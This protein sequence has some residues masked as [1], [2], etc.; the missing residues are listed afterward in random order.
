[1]GRLAVDNN[2]AQLLRGCPSSRKKGNKIS[3]KGEPPNGAVSVRRGLLMKA[4]TEGERWGV[5]EAAVALKLIHDELR[6]RQLRGQLCLF[7]EELRS[8]SLL[9]LKGGFAL[10]ISHGDRER[11]VDPACLASPKREKERIRETIIV[12]ERVFPPTK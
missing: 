11:K 10:I 7:M 12:L 2:T 4:S 6:P 1:M 5:G 3:I 8:S 9:V